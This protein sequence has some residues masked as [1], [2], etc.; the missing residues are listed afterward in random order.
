MAKAWIAATSGNRNVSEAALPF[1]DSS[2]K[3][4]QK[5]YAATAKELGREF[6]P[7]KAIEL[8]AQDSKKPKIASPEI[9]R[10][11]RAATAGTTVVQDPSAV[12]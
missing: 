10:K 6:G 3:A 4:F 5:W 12:N 11:M 1:D 7:T 2:Y 8:I 9:A